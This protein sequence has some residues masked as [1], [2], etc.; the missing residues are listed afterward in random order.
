MTKPIQIRNEDVAADVRELAARRGRSIT[1]MIA[2]LVRPELERERRRG[3]P[4][5]RRREIARIVAEFRALPRRGKP[6]TDDDLYDEFGLP[7]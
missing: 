2:Q 7:K 5:A 1:E 4:E 6:L 3:D